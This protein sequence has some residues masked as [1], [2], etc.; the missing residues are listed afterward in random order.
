MDEGASEGQK[1]QDGQSSILARSH[2]KRIGPD[3]GETMPVAGA[4]SLEIGGSWWLAD[5]Q[6]R[7][8]LSEG[9]P[10]LLDIC[11]TISCYGRRLRLGSSYHLIRGC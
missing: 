11:A 10:V 2:R 5:D 6:R 3:H 7:G 4:I 1:R 8:P 9:L